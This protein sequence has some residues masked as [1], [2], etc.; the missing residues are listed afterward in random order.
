M[1]EETKRLWLRLGDGDDYH[2][3]DSIEEVKEVLDECDC[4]PV[5]RHCQYGVNGNRH[6]KGLN[7]ISLYWGDDDAQPL[8]SITDDELVYLNKEAD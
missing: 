8:S 7:Y 3:F 4:L 2:D 5:K 1:T 6:Y